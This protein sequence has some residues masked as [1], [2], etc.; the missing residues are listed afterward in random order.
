MG[1]FQE[2]WDRGGGMSS[3]QGEYQQ[4]MYGRQPAA[5]GDDISTDNSIDN[6]TTNNFHGDD[7]SNE[8]EQDVGMDVDDGMDR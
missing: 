5:G 7:I 2:A 8:P 3:I 1:A 4:A 6:S